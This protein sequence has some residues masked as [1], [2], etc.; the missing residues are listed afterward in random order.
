MSGHSN[1]RVATLTCCFDAELFGHWW[2][3]GVHFLNHAI[4]E[5]LKR[6]VRVSSAEQRLAEAPPQKVVWLPEGSWGE[7]ADHRVWFNDGSRWM[8]EV[9]WRAEERIQQL[10][11]RLIR[12]KKGGT[13]RQKEI[14]NQLKWA[15]SLLLASD[16][17]FVISSG[18]A[19]DYGHQRFAVAHHRFEQLSLALDDLL[20]H[21]PLSQQRKAA[22]EEIKAFQEAPAELEHKDL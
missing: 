16:W 5:L 8:W 13:K 7:G 9:M 11:E 12:Q 15:L 22:L 14:F 20:E 18:G 10:E 4:E 2:F 3:E 6:G 19:V 17:I 1:G 21:R